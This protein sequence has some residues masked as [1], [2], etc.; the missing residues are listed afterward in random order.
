[1]A[2]DAAMV[3]MAIDGALADAAFAE[4]P[5]VESLSV[6]RLLERVA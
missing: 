4:D 3:A 2:D 5:T 1:M 6:T